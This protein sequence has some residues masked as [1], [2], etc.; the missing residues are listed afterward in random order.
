[1]FKVRKDL[2]VNRIAAALEPL[3]SVEVARTRNA[4]TQYFDTFDWR[5]FDAGFSVCAG[6]GIEGSEIHLL[7]NTNCTTLATI[8]GQLATGFA[9]DFPNSKMRNNIERVIDMR[10]LL[11]RLTI[12]SQRVLFT[13][14]DK[15]GKGIFGAVLEK[16]RAQ[17]PKGGRTIALGTFLTL[18]PVKGYAKAGARAHGMLENDVAL[19]LLDKP[20]QFDAFEALDIKPGD[21]S[22]K[23]K[24]QLD[25]AMTMLDAVRTVHL[26]L[27]ET[28]ERNEIG[29]AENIDPEFLHDFRVA[30]RR[31]RSALSQLDKGVLS[32]ALITKAKRDFQWISQ[33][34][35]Q[36]RDL[37]VYLIDFPSLQAPL[38]D[39]YK[40][41]LQPFRNYLE[42]RNQKESKRVAAMVTGERYRNIR[43]GWQ[44][45]FTEGY[46]NQRP[47]EMAQAPVKALADA[48]IW[49]AYRKA[50]K[51]GSAIEDH[52][53]AT[54]LHDLRITC[55]KLRYLLEFFQ[56]L[57]PPEET[58]RLIKA[59]KAFQNILGEFQDTEVQSRAI[60]DFGK[61]MAEANAVPVETHMAMGMVAESILNRQGAARA[62]FKNRFDAFSQDVVVA[63]FAKLFKNTE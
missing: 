47:T 5:L 20:L 24:L 50:M 44:A 30:I 36:M 4:K 53:P 41:Y 57:Y 22:S 60:L 61:E 63:S 54:D 7:D 34:T 56:S 39:P 62:D 33:K 14:R 13:V 48:R 16:S 59:V 6:L 46:K 3:G 8:S 37:D 51:E 17:R 55:K 28:M 2:S 38:P 32:S 26:T 12:F 52:S 18:K 42:V 58:S 45:Y 35:N 25:P 23:L 10:R 19:T 1:M 27:L 31:T 15:E 21:Y 49:K 40:G 29:T 11:P 9:S 43:F